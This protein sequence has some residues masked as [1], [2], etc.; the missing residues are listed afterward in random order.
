[1]NLGLRL[2]AYALMFVGAADAPLFAAEK[3]VKPNLVIILAE[4]YG[5]TS[6]HWGESF[7]PP[8]DHN[9]KFIRGQGYVADHFTEHALAFIETNKAR[10]FF[11][12][13]PFYTPHSPFCVPDEYWD[14]FKDKPITMRGVD[15]E[16]ENVPVTRAAL[17]MCENI[18]WDGKD[19]SPL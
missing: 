13:L 1:M 4:Y 14:R 19:I 11:C 5:F 9:G 7:D 3:S 18:D 10:P 16:K 8:L 6:G 2:I 12:Y 17:A 15:G